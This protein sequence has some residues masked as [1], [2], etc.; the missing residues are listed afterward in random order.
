MGCTSSTAS[1]PDKST[2]PASAAKKPNPSASTASASKARKAGAS[3]VTVKSQPEKKAAG[4]TNPQYETQL[5][6][7]LSES[8]GKNVAFHGLLTDAGTLS[9]RRAGNDGSN[10][11]FSTSLHPQDD[12]CSKSADP[13]LSV[14]SGVA[15]T[16][17]Y[18]VI[19]GKPN[20]HALITAEISRTFDLANTTV[21]GWNPDS[22]ISKLNCFPPGKKTAISPYL[23]NLFDAVDSVYALTDGRFDPTTG[24]L[25]SAFENC[26][27]EKQ[28]PPL[29]SE[30]K[31]FK[32]AVGWKK[33]IVRTDT[34]VSR[35]N[36]NSVIDLDGISKGFVIDR[37]VEALVQKGFSD[38]YVDWAGDVRACGNHP[39]GRAWRSAVVMPPPLARMFGHW[40]NGTLK[41]MLKEDDIGYMADFSFGNGSPEGAIATSGDYFSLQK[42]GYHH[43]ARADDMTIMKSNVN[44]VASVSV[45]ARDCAT[46]DAVATAAMT[47]DT[48]QQTQSFLKGLCGSHPDLV[49]GYCVL[50]RN[51]V[52]SDS[53]GH[54]SDG[55]FFLADN[56]KR[57]KVS[58]DVTS[59]ESSSSGV[60]VA[61]MSAVND[62]IIHNSAIIHFNGSSVEVTSWVPCSVKPEQVVT[63]IVPTSF[64]EKA[65]LVD[66]SEMNQLHCFVLSSDS[67]AKDGV[68]ITMSFRQLFDL[69]EGVLVA[70]AI[71]GIDLGTQT[72]A[73]VLFRETVLATKSLTLSTSRSKF[74]LSPLL[75]QCKDIFRSIPSMVWIVRTKSADQTEFALTATSVSIP[76][77]SQNF[78]CFN[79]AHSSAF[80]AGLGG[81]GAHVQAYALSSAQHDL[82]DTH[83]VKSTLEDESA[84]ALAADCMVEIK[85][86]VEVVES[87]QDHIVVL[88]R[89][90][91]V[92]T[93][94]EGDLPLVWIHGGLLETEG[95]L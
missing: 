76:N 80:Y 18:C 24:V 41:E 82:A 73:K 16:M 50:D 87:V 54:F 71:T 19:V 94:N 31:N 88:L 44:S 90:T 93:D 20:A 79:I 33:R 32:F 47:F 74:H 21:N 89:V 10:K 48:S 43:I 66:G 35:T 7:S 1:N 23:S 26:I 22:E 40:K 30:I 92:R 4:A 11:I 5:S 77:F 15:M 27:R 34:K 86:C 55:I 36:G 25:S 12:S 62:N 60:D 72:S 61:K 78:L 8:G 65:S 75:S 85:G 42:Y 38:C 68:R 91:E 46:A 53:T 14:V 13:T 95:S 64:A 45:A 70:A 3:A 6:A 52:N 37:I 83:S 69:G 67:S 58:D 2:T 81:I 84:K 59:D 28:R 56:S 63:F 17:P 49:F 39:S 51:A 57:L 9:T 29:P